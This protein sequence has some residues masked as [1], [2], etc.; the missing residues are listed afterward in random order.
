L[1]WVHLSDF[2]HAAAQVTASDRTVR[3]AAG[4]PWGAETRRYRQ[5][6]ALVHEHTGW[7]VVGRHTQTLSRNERSLVPLPELNVRAAYLVDDTTGR[8]LY[9]YHAD[10][11]RYVASTA[12][13]LTALVALQHLHLTSVVTVPPDALVG[14]TT[15]NL[16][17]G[18]R[19]RVRDLFYGMLL[20]SG[21]DAAVTLADAAAG[22]IP[23]FAVWMNQKARQLGLRSSHFVTPHGMDVQGQYSTARDLTRIARALLAQPFLAEVARTKVYDTRSSDGIYHHWVNLNQLLSAYPGTIGVKTGHTPLAGGCL[24]SADIRH[25]HRLIGVVLGDTV[26]GRFSDS[27]RLLDYGWRVLGY[28]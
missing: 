17:A 23:A 2:D 21:N 6:L 13:M 19:L 18:E 9:A 11:P 14:G 26:S 27:K 16:V 12:K 20:P 4:A 22:S 5:E 8:D 24:V 15:A 10:T 7:R 25:G 1:N 3:Y 28:G